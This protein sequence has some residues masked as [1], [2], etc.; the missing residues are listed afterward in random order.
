MNV[1]ITGV[2]EK[3]LNKMISDGYASTK[4]EAIRLAIISFGKSKHDI[5]IEM[6]NRKIDWIEEQ[7][8]LGKRKTL[9]PEEALGK[10]AKYITYP[11]A[12]K[13]SK[14]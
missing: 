4:S 14:K 3:I 11:Y 6:V 10:Y 13:K 9:T 2:P 7:V 5:E 1:T 8:R 12:N